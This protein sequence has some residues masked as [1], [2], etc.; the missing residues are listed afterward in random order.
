[1]GVGNDLITGTYSGDATFARRVFTV[2]QTVNRATPSIQPSSSAN[3]SLTGNAA[4]I[5]ATVT[6]PYGGQQPSGTLTVSEG[7]STLSSQP[8]D[9]S[10]HAQFTLASLALGP[11]TLTFTYGGDSN[12]GTATFNFSRDVQNRTTLS[13]ASSAAAS[14][15]GTT[16]P[17]TAAITSQG[18]PTPTGTVNFNADGVSFGTATLDGNGNAALSTT[19]TPDGTHKITATYGGDS[20]SA[21]ATSNGVSVSV[22]NFSASPSPTSAMIR[23]GQSATFNLAVTSLG[24][25]NNAVTFTCSGVPLYATCNFN[26]TSVTPPANGSATVQLTITTAG[27]AAALANPMHRGREIYSAFAILGFG[28]LVCIMFV[29]AQWKRGWSLCVLGECLLLMTILV[30]CGG[31]GAAGRAHRL[32]GSRPWKRVSSRLR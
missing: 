21:A 32:R 3:P 28:G 15:A 5:G 8:L 20:Y 31:G 10:S 6:A 14:V 4:T 16:I 13:L 23:A 24:G 7:Q 2:T 12:F 18:P 1:M 11:H 9:N 26:P 25:F 27:T 22:A 29:S 17:Y 30:G 19:A